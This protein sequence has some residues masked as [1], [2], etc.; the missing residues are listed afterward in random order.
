[1]RLQIPR[2]LFKL[3]PAG[4]VPVPLSQASVVSSG[5]TQRRAPYVEHNFIKHSSI[6]LSI[7][8]FDWCCAAFARW[9]GCLPRGGH[10]SVAVPLGCASLPLHLSHRTHTA[11]NMRRVA[12]GLFNYVFALSS[13]RGY[14]YLVGNLIGM[15]PGALLFTLLGAQVRRTRA[16]EE[17]RG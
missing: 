7:R 11:R 3:R 16:R 6:L 12:G 10:G 15:A 5:W 8:T 2:N 13:V 1:M 14:A 4:L 9:A 17:R